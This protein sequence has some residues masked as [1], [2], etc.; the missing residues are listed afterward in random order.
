MKKREIC[1][2]IV[3]DGNCEFIACAKCPLREKSCTIGSERVFAR[4]WLKKHPKKVSYKKY[5]EVVAKYAESA[6]KNLII[7]SEY[8][9]LVEKYT[10][11]KESSWKREQKPERQNKWHELNPDDLPHDILT[12]A[13]EFAFPDYDDKKKYTDDFPVAYILSHARGIE[14]RDG[15]KDAFIHGKRHYRRIER[16]S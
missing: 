6:S 10:A 13:Y 11:L 15:M 1:K 12:G 9:D 2:K 4:D 14:L 16:Q 8:A 3:K 5:K 7:V